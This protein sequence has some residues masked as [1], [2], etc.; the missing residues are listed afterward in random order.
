M[1]HRVEQGSI[2]IFCREMTSSRVSK[3]HPADEGQQHNSVRMVY[4]KL[5]LHKMTFHVGRI[6]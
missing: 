6:G 5:C 1:A 4:E 3:F 2:L